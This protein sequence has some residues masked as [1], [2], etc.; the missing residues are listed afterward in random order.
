MGSKEPY[1]TGGMH[2]SILQLYE[3][4]LTG[5]EAFL[6]NEGG[7]AESV[8]GSHLRPEQSRNRYFLASL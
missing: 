3:D 7:E 4:A 6:A 1:A 2:T 5:I 8:D